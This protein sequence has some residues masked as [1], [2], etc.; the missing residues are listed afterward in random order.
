MMRVLNGWI[1]A[2]LSLSLSGLA[3]AQTVEDGNQAAAADAAWNICNETS[4]ILRLAT[5]Q[6]TAGETQV[7]GWQK[8]RPSQCL[9]ETPDLNSARFLFAESAAVHNGGIR[10]WAGA[11]TICVNPQE[12]FDIDTS[13]SCVLQGLETRRF[14]RIDPKEMDTTLIEP[15]DFKGKAKTAGLQ[16]LMKDAGYKISR[17]D[18]I[19]GRRTRNTLKQFLK[20]YEIGSDLPLF[21]KMDALEDAALSQQDL[22]GLTLCNQTPVKTW[23]AIGYREDGSWQSRGWWA[24]DPEDCVRPWSKELT[25]TEMHIYAYQ[26]GE[27]DVN[28]ILQNPLETMNNFCIAEAKFSAIGREF[29]TDKGYVPANFR[30]IPTTEKGLQIN[31]SANDFI[32][33]PNGG[34]RQ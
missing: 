21:E 22:T 7:S 16:R 23:T 9:K 31:L 18:G 5:A 12:N 11:V 28:A 34:L 33:P 8:L 1:I 6:T 25:G 2:L 3:A 19:D 29:C 10:E 14:L 13:V 20:D 17:I 32:T 30:S 24:I 27:G 4:F 26:T 15:D